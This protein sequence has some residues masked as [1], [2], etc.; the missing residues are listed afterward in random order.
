MNKIIIIFAFV[1]LAGCETVQHRPT[2]IENPNDGAVILRFLP[3][4]TSATQFF[5]N[6]QSVTVEKIP[7]NTKEKSIKYFL[8][9]R[10]D[11]ASRTAT[12]AGAL[13]P[14]NYKFLNFSSQSCGAICISSSLTV[15]PKF[16]QFEIKSAT[17]TDLGVIVSTAV[18]NNSSILA[19]DFSSNHPETSEIVKETIPE[20]SALIN[21]PFLSWSKNTVPEQ[22]PNLYEYSRKTS[23]GFSSPQETDNGSF[24]YGSANG[25]VYNWTPGQ[26]RKA[27]DVGVRS[28]IESL[29]AL[30]NGNWIAGG[31]LGVL[32]ISKDKGKTW[33]SIRNNLPFGVVVDLHEWN[34][35]I[36]ATILRE[37]NVYVFATEATTINWSEVAHYQMELSTF[38]DIAGVRPQSFLTTLPGRKIASY[39]LSNNEKLTYP[40]P[41]AIQMFSISAD[42][43]LRCR[44]QSGIMV[45]PYESSDLGKTWK[46]STSSRFMLMPAFRDQLHGVSFKGGFFS[47]SKMAYT[48]DGGKTW[49]ETT[50]APVYFNNL[51]YSKDGKSAYAAS[52]FG[53]FWV[54]RNDGKSW[55][56]LPR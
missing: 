32:K 34:G 41:G 49:V 13:P 38:W 54:T 39:D 33:S 45:N 40:L 28:S 17:L 37:N 42:G 9:P 22:M 26:K 23:F 8:T 3:N 35:K 21:T 55:E 7:S 16:S 27:F 18:E 48:E 4:Q 30:K 6:W 46:E 44:C 25:I 29:A 15:N 52:A 14:G 24:I 50:E 10:L 12:Y 2:K 19:H 11:G 43:I 56:S 1:F 5:K 53:D 36:I 31:E 51:F 47:P 20:F